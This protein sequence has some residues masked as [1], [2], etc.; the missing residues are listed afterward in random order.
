M[1]HFLGQ[2]ALGGKGETTG[3]TRFS[4]LPK[5]GLSVGQPVSG[6][7]PKRC[8]GVLMGLGVSD[9]CSGEC[10]CGKSLYGFLDLA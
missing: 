5:E 10:F 2:S 3:V 7:M 1:S 4:A 9:G 8:A 6:G